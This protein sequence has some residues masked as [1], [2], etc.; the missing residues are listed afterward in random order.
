MNK[1]HS[2]AKEL[3]FFSMPLIFSGILQQLYSWA[4]AFIV[5]HADGETSLAAIGATN[6]IS[7]FL[8]N[9]ILGLTLGIS[10]MAAQEYGKGNIGRIRRLVSLYLPFML[11]VFILLTLLVSLFAE[12]ILAFMET[13]GELTKL[14]SDYLMIVTAGV[15]FLAV[16]NL[17]AAVFRALGD[18]KASFYAILVSSAVN[19]L[20]DI[21]FVAALGYGVHG[22]AFATV[23]SQALM[24]LFTI[25][26]AVKKHPELFYGDRSEE[27]VF[28]QGLGFALPPAIQNSVI[29]L[30]NLILQN[31]MNSFGAVTVLAITT[32]Y[33]V[34][35]LMLL[36]IINLGSAIATMVARSLGEGNMTKVKAYFKSGITVMAAVTG[37]LTLLMF[38]FGSVF[39]SV[40]GVSTEALEQGRVFF[41]D[42]SIFYMLFGLATALRSTLE[43][44]GDIK[45]ASF[46]GIFTL[47]VRIAFSYILKPLAAERTIAFAEGV[48][49]T[50][51]FVAVFV[52]ILYKKKSIG[53]DT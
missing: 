5:G 8:I 14:S 42:L 17:F 13:P 11:I 52:R 43:G 41:R 26:Y 45:F 32:S 28:R 12:D 40:F 33:R 16:Y 19:V 15:P 36:P 35:S 7:T 4:D 27:K 30:G 29:S 3:I 34:D 24:T 50:V 23:V 22:A 20:L 44:L 49:W 51:F 2:Y 37:L 38:F 39:V 31:F 47:A 10:I 18:T 9:T 53:F 25:A 6:S 1:K 48:A 21:L 46:V